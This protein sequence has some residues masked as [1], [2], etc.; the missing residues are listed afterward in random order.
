MTVFSHFQTKKL[1]DTYS[2]LTQ[3]EKPMQTQSAGHTELKE[4][5]SYE[6][7]LTKHA[8]ISRKSFSSKNYF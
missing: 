6:N 7:F 3:K 4:S 2:I 8:S 1:A 5:I